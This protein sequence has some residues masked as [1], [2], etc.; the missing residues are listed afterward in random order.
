MVINV[1]SFLKINWL[2][3]SKQRFNKLYVHT[4]SKPLCKSK[5]TLYV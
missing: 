3:N 1:V 2:V 4:V 5:I